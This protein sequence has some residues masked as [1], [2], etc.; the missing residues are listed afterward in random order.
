M[1]PETLVRLLADPVRLRV[2]AAV[3]LGA[4][5][6]AETA[7]AAGLAAKEAAVARG[8][9]VEGGLL[10][11]GAQGWEV[12]HSALREAARQ[13]AAARSSAEPEEDEGA[14]G[15]GAYV[16]GRR[17]LSLPSRQARRY[18]VLQHLAST[19]FAAGQRYDERAVNELLAAWCAG[20]DVD[21]V[22]VRRY[23]VDSGLLVRGGGIY[24]LPSA[25]PAPEADA[26]ERYVRAMGLT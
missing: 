20:G 2:L 17:L 1:T 18:A 25:E 3:A 24:S 23:L 16:R 19:T 9:L 22:T 15:L 4:R 14:E 13:Q 10:V 5:T 11:Q 12:G 6:D 26:A 8:R 21:H 7:V